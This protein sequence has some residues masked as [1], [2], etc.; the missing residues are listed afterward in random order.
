M[1]F[2]LEKKIPVG[3]YTQTNIIRMVASTP[4]TSN[5]FQANKGCIE[6]HFATPS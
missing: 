4:K 5:N 2:G 3:I 1:A 6:K